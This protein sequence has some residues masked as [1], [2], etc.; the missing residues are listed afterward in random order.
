MKQIDVRFQT[1]SPVIISDAGNSA[2]MTDTKKTI[3]G[4]VLRGVFAQKYIEK[5]NCGKLAHQDKKFRELFF[6]KIRFVDANPLIGGARSFVLPFSLQK[7]K[8]SDAKALPA[9]QDL[10]KTDSPQDGF[11][12]FRGMAI[13]EDGNALKQVSIHTNITLHMSRGSAKERLIGSS[14][15]GNIFNYES[16]DAGQYFCGSIIGEDED[17][18]ELL[19]NCGM[20]EKGTFSCRIGRSKFT[21]YGECIAALGEM[22]ECLENVQV[23]KDIQENSVL[24]RMDT[25]YIPTPQYM[26]NVSHQLKQIADL[27]NEPEGGDVFDIR[28]IYSAA[29]KVENFNG[30]CGMKQP[31]VNALAAG[32]VFELHRKDGTDWTEKEIE[33][34]LS[35][36]YEGVGMRREEGFGQLRIWPWENYRLAVPDKS[37]KKSE[38]EQSLKNM[39]IGD[40]PEIVQ[41]QVKNILK[42][43]ILEQ[44]RIYADEDAEKMRIPNGM[45]HFFAR[46]LNILERAR[47]SSNTRDEMK[48]RLLASFRHKDTLVHAKE[49]EQT[50]MERNLRKIYLGDT[51]LYDFLCEESGLPYDISAARSWKKDLS[52]TEGIMDDLLKDIPMAKE[53][54]NLAANEYFYEYWHWLLRSA[55]KTSATKTRRKA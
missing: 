5:N 24:L 4:T 25:P 1:I 28:K 38:K 55:R 17:L 29:D 32:T 44:L 46:L 54:T 42:M 7:E 51:T 22:K 35:I 14:K 50:P 11:K 36:L 31:R 40:V 18:R 49:K 30:V 19:R 21:E 2:I 26:G 13:L 37:K 33:K 53:V 34:L 27:M 9:V 41:R 10:L 20:E 6:K 47:N 15:D 48:E 16:I 52:E 8:A 43:R 3:S 45:T 23:K 39:E 12:S